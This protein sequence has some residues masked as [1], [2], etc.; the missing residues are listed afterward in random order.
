M[1]W[2]KRMLSGTSTIRQLFVFLWQEKLWWMIPMLVV[3][4]LFSGVLMFTQSAAATPFI[5]TLF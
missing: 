1:G 2:F 3:L 4:L 5:Y